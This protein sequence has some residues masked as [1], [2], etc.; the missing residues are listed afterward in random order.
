MKKVS[1]PGAKETKQPKENRINNN[2]WNEQPA[3]KPVGF[4]MLNEIIDESYGEESSTGVT[5]SRHKQECEE[6]QRQLTK[7]KSRYEN[8][9]NVE[10]ELLYGKYREHFQLQSKMV[11]LNRIIAFVAKA[12]ENQQELGPS[13][14]L[15]SSWIKVPTEAQTTF[16][17]LFYRIARGETLIS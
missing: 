3:N 10:K 17:K 11:Q 14:P 9:L 4:G 15:G 13:I 2:P 8:G 16:V 5:A 6:V 12:D 1:K 7:M